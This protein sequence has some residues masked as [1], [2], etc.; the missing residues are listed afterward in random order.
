MLLL[1]FKCDLKSLGRDLSHILNILFIILAQG[2]IKYFE[3]FY[4]K[5]D[6]KSLGHHFGP[7]TLSHILNI[8]FIGVP[9]QAAHFEIFIKYFEMC[10]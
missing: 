7:G 4:L 2:F 5:C 10:Y 8:L 6:L 9:N 1:V 3:I